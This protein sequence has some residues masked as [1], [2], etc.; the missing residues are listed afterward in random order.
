MTLQLIESISV[1]LSP[2]SLVISLGILLLLW[3]IFFIRYPILLI[4]PILKELKAFSILLSS[5]DNSNKDNMDKLEK[6]FSDREKKSVLRTI[7]SD[8][9]ENRSIY[10]DW[11]EYF[12]NFSLIDV[13]AKKSQTYSIPSFLFTIG[14][15][16]SFFCFL[17]R[18]TTGNPDQ[19]LSQILYP[20]VVE[21]V[22]IVFI[23]LLLSYL[24]D[25]IVQSMF[26]RAEGWVYEINK[27]LRRKLPQNQDDTH[28]ERITAALDNMSI[29]MS[30]YAKNL[31]DMQHDGMNQLVDIFLDGL[32]SKMDNQLQELGEAFKSFSLLQKETLSQTGGYVNELSRGVEI[33]R[34]INVASEA[35]ISAIAQHYEQISN[36]SQSL[37]DNLTELQSLSQT[38]NDIVTFNSD[39]LENIKNERHNLKEEYE[40]TIQYI[41]ESIKEYQENTSNDIG[42]TL[43]KFSD[44]SEKMLKELEGSVFDT[45]NAFTDNHKSALQ[46]LE[47]H[48]RNMNNAT[49]DISLHISQLNSNLQTTIKEFMHAVEK[50]TYK[51]ITEFDEGLAEITLRLSNTITE[52]RDSIDDLPVIIDSF[53]KR[54]E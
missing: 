54:L 46:S 39:I 30:N 23:A 1:K 14:L 4:N 53:A 40:N 15:A 42:Q 12:N 26:N 35:I 8:F 21:V 19:N 50:G 27:L 29:S 18:F 17:L 16:L 44:I 47:E 2:F 49:Q 5:F 31:A 22:V 38:L 34:Q 33:Q 43:V 51:T 10:P 37:A 52:I 28:Y 9:I 20:T 25:R 24:Y 41:F 45:V 48:F 32:H 13:P 3:I 6:Y 11:D 36:S 7:W